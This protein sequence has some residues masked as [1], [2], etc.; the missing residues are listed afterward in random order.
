D[1][2][3]QSGQ[4]LTVDLNSSDSSLSI[5]PETALSVIGGRGFNIWYLYHNLVSGADPLG[6]ENIL[7]ISCG[8]LTG[9]PAP[10]S[11][12]LHLN[13]LSPLTGI[14]GSSNVGGYAGAWLRSCNIASIVIKG[15]S[16][17]PVYLYIDSHGARLKDASHLWGYDAFATQDMIRHSHEN[18]K[19]R[20]LAIGPGGE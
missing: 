1:S 20:I 10:S 3:N 11:A 14:L 2:P 12:R 4:L 9:S 16:S 15:K 5:F 19:I 17:K 13:A 6:P 18:E 7:L 8:L